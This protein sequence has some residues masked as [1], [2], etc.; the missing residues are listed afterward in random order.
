MN[1]KI[2]LISICKTLGEKGFGNSSKKGGEGGDGIIRDKFTE[3]WRAL[4]KLRQ[5]WE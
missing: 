5:M 3:G 4:R 2:C 1:L